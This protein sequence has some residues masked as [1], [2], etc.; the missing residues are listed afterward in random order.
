MARQ[1]QRWQ[2]A[3]SAPGPALVRSPQK[4]TTSCC[5]FA[6]R[7]A[8]LGTAVGERGAHSLA[9]KYEASVRSLGRALPSP[10]RARSFALPETSCASTMARSTGPVN[11]RFPRSGDSP[12]EKSGQVVD[13][14]AAACGQPGSALGMTL[15]METGGTVLSCPVPPDWLVE[16]KKVRV[17]GR[18]GRQWCMAYSDGRAGHPP[19]QGS[20]RRIRVGDRPPAV[21]PEL[22]GTAHT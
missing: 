5:P 18:L 3:G 8:N 11:A 14:R 15:G 6:A 1:R 19:N 12:V 20:T 21:P 2:R 10:Y 9:N 16:E 17:S 7:G 13:G 22:L 4:Q